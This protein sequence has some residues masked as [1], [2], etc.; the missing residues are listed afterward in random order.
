M[1]DRPKQVYVRGLAADDEIDGLQ[2]ELGIS[3][4]GSPKPRRRAGPSL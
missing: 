2:D 1:A 3:D 4:H